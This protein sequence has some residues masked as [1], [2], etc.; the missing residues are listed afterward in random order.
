MVRPTL[1]LFHKIINVKKRVLVAKWVQSVSLVQIIFG[2]RPRDTK[3][4]L[5]I[6]LTNL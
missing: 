4:I 2:P 3:E 1:I 5:N 6:T